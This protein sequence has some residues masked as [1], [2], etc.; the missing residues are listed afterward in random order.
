MMSSAADCT[1]VVVV[2]ADD[3]AVIG[4]SCSYTVGAGDGWGWGDASEAVGARGCMAS[5]E[6]GEV[7]DG[8]GECGKEMV[9]GIGVVVSL[10]EAV[11]VEPFEP[12]APVSGVGEL[13]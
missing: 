12:S 4:C 5:P 6:C 3:T 8:K 11:V 1:A 13:V 7:A 10:D 2:E 9:V